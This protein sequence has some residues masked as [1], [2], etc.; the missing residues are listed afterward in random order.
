MKWVGACSLAAPGGD[1]NLL[2]LATD[3][4]EH[5]PVASVGPFG[6]NFFGIGD[7]VEGL[8]RQ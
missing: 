4:V 7:D 5:Q 8:S 2:G 1:D 3:S 6:S